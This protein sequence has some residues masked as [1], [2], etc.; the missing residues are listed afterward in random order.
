M[1]YNLTLHLLEKEEKTSIQV[2]EVFDEEEILIDLFTPYNIKLEEVFEQENLLKLLKN[3]IEY[4]KSIQ[5]EPDEFIND[6]HTIEQMLK[7]NLDVLENC[8]SI[9]IFLHPFLSKY[10]KENDF[11]KNKK[12]KLADFLA[13]T[14][15]DLDKVLSFLDD[16]DNIYVSIDGNKNEVTIQQ[17]KNTVEEI[18]KI[19]SKVQKYELSPLEKMMYAYDLVRDRVYNEEKKE[20]SHTASRDLTSVLFGDKIVCVGFA[21]IFEKVLLNLGMKNKMYRIASEN[22]RG[23]RRNVVYVNDPKYHIEGVFF[24]DPTWNSKKAENDNHYLDSYKFFCKSQEEMKKYENNKFT[25]ITFAGYDK[26]F[27]EKFKSMVT[28][29][30]IGIV[31]NNV[32]HTINEISD[33]IDEK[34]LI[35]PVFLYEELYPFDLEKTLRTLNRYDKLFFDSHLNTETLLRI[36]LQVRKIEYYENPEKYPWTVESFEMVAEDNDSFY[37]NQRLLALLSSENWMEINE[38]IFRIDFEKFKDQVEL[39]KNIE[40]IKLTKI[41]RN[42]AKTK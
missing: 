2:S 28:K 15:E 34:Q 20:E 27:T 41:L 31:P 22:Q 12:L 8:D 14:R 18:E 7:G 16:Y 3:N 30:G 29:D 6:I 32:I 9:T 23:H 17:Y 1:K 40:R 5:T 11:L 24:C 13:I 36:L 25:N 4:L 33:L 35:K 38:N 21:N 39:E 10:I 26:D 42:I 19:V 37:N